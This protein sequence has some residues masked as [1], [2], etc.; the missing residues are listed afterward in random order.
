LS[1]GCADLR[2]DAASQRDGSSTLVPLSNGEAEVE[3]LP[4]NSIVVG[5]KSRVLKTIFSSGMRESDKGSPVVLKMTREGE[6]EVQTTEHM[7]P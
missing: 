2:Q 7:S 4:I 3:E 5:A 1:P 6:I